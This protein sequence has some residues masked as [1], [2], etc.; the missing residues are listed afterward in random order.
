MK[1]AK[2]FVAILLALLMFGSTVVMAA[3]GTSVDDPDFNDVMDEKTMASVYKEEYKLSNFVL[4]EVVITLKKGI[5][6]TA[7]YEEL[8]P[9]VKIVQ[10]DRVAAESF[11]KGDLKRQIIV[12]KLEEKSRELVLET[13]EALKEND[14]V[15]Y[16]RPNY[17]GIVMDND[18]TSAATP[19]DVNKDGK[20]GNDD[21]IMTARHVVKLAVLEG[22]EF[23]AADINKD[24]TVN[25][26]D[27]IIIA[28]T[29][30]G[31]D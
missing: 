15:Y 7:G 8:F 29:V 19:G 12:I 11:D 28:K 31:L 18:N 22:A 16:V 4:D 21:L 9:N 27:V 30:V 3:D 20:V 13:V 26:Q 1:N 24:S 6:R 17:T 25:N 14:F 10:V 2:R 23:T 5:N